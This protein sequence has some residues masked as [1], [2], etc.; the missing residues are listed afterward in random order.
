M[1]AKGHCKVSDL[2]LAVMT[3]DKVKGYAGTPGYTA[4]EVI[5]MQPYNKMADFFSFGVLIYRLLSG[6]VK[7]CAHLSV[8]DNMIHCAFCRNLLVLIQVVAT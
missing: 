4:P 7:Y 3:N 6:K 1:D 2:G 5:L 8:Q